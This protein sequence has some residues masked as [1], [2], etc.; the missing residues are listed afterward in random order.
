[1]ESKSSMM[2]SG[3]F[4][5]HRHRSHPIHSS[6]FAA[7][8][9]TQLTTFHVGEA[10]TQNRGVGGGVALK[11][12]RAYRIAQLVAGPD[13]GFVEADETCPPRIDPVWVHRIFANLET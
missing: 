13:T 8:A 1:M 11:R 7:G 9:V 10:R 6:V 3:P 2:C 4:C 5:V 12:G